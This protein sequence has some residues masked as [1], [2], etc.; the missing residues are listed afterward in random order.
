MRR[1]RVLAT[2][3]AQVR[4][5]VDLVLDPTLTDDEYRT[6]IDS[7]IPR[8]ANRATSQNGPYQRRFVIVAQLSKQAQ[9]L[10]SRARTAADTVA[11]SRA[12]QQGLLD[13]V[14]NDVILPQQ[15]WEIA[16]LL[17]MQTHLQHEQRE[18]RQGVMTPELNAV[19][20]PQQAALQRSIMTVTVRVEALE[21]YAYR[22]QE[23]D[24]AL[25]AREALQNNDKYR[26]LLAH[27]DDTEGLTQLTAQANALERTVANNVRHA[28]EAGQTLSL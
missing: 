23:T 4:D 15:I 2:E 26:A 3:R 22:V 11:R 13:A 9:R 18:A 10:L 25:R 7:L 24:A 8:P 1:K 6:V 28:I 19:L 27:T 21:K 20:E 5:T 17:Q 14:A 16:R 12:K